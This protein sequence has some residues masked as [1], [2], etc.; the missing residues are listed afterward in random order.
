MHKILTIS[1]AVLASPLTHAQ[2]PT[3]DDRDWIGV[4]VGFEKSTLKFQ[5]GVEGAA[6]VFPLFKDKQIYP[7]VKIPVTIELEETLPGGGFKR[8]PIIPASLESSQKPTTK[9]KSC[10]V[11]GKFEGDAS[12]QVTLENDGGEVVM[13]GKLTDEGAFKDR[14]VRLVIVAEI[15]NFYGR[16]ERKL[17]GNKQAFEDLVKESSLT[18]FT[19]E[20]KKE[21]LNF[22]E[23]L[24]RDSKASIVTNEAWVELAIVAKKTFRFEATGSSSLR[25]DP[26]RSSPLHRGAYVVWSQSAGDSN[27]AGSLVIEVD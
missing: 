5:F 15:L 1:L 14:D 7:Y 11:T 22:A 8:H 12:F 19:K 16:E 10:D 4:F 18:Y 9:L 13:S 25:L 23:S 26:R 3:I 17:E 6:L 27:R 2:L 20:K 21:R 24:V